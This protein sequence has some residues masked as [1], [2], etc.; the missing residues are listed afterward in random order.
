MPG[1][2]RRASL[3]SEQRLRTIYDGRYEYIGVLAPDGTL[4][5][6]AFLIY[7]HGDRREAPWPAPLKRASPAGWR[8]FP[9]ASPL[10]PAN[11]AGSGPRCG[12]GSRPM[13]RGGP[14]APAV[15]A[16]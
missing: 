5:D 12:T 15:G 7:R 14:P 6:V 9:F 10:I 8:P 16:A 13:G 4:L 11:C 1:R 2:E 3:E